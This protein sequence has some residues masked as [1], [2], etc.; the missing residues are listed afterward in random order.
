MSKK[1]EDKVFE[2]LQFIYGDSVAKPLLSRLI[3]RLRVFKQNHPDLVEIPSNKPRVT[4]KDAILITYGDMVQTKDQTPIQTL[5]AFTEH[6]IKDLIST[7]H[8]LPFFP[9]SSDDG[10]SVIDYKQVD[11]NLGDWDDIH[12]LGEYFRLMFD[13]VINHISAKS[14]WFQ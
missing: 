10:F 13:A 12:D 7:V 6:H 5:S 9:Y 11:P 1:A 2:H 4:E 14:D 8:I 3:E